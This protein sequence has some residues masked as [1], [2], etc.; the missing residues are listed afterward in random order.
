LIE[1]LIISLDSSTDIRLREDML[2]PSQFVEAAE[3]S[4]VV[5]T[6]AAGDTFVGAYAVRMV[7]REKQKPVDKA[8]IKFACNAAAR[9]VEKAGAQSAIPWSDEVDQS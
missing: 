6:T 3:V 5:D 1:A 4:N 2:E 7:R 9:T 8:A